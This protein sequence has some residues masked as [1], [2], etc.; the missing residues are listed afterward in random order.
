MS[1]EV[2]YLLAWVATMVAAAIVG[3]AVEE[4]SWKDKAEF[5]KP[6]YRGDN[7]YKVTRVG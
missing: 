1:N 2:Y 7:V 6:V 5:G 3:A 4:N